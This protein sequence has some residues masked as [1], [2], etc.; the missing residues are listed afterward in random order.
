M[1]YNLKNVSDTQTYIFLFENV[2]TYSCCY[3]TLNRLKT[4]FFPQLIICARYLIACILPSSTWKALVAL[5][6]EKASRTSTTETVDSGSIPGRVKP[7]TMK[8]VF[9]VFLLNGQHQK[10]PCEASTV[11]GRQVAAW[12]VIAKVSSQ[13]IGFSVISIS[14]YNCKHKHFTSKI[15]RW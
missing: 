5:G 4:D 15:K 12:L 13:T 11:C 6:R 2:Q 14:N 10:W 1:L 9:L 7:K 8:I 3:I